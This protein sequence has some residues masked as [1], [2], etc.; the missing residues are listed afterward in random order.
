[1]KTMKRKQGYK[2]LQDWRYWD[3]VMKG[4]GNKDIGIQKKKRDREKVR[5]VYEKK[6]NGKQ[7]KEIRKTV[8]QTVLYFSI[9]FH[10]LDQDVG[11]AS[12]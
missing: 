10:L 2:M 8:I 5:R 4:L 11:I 6:K 1:M 3:T 7:Y 9:S 12:N